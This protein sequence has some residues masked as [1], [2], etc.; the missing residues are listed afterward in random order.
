MSV[1]RSLPATIARSSKCRWGKGVDASE[2]GIRMKRRRLLPST[3]RCG[4]NIPPPA[5]HVRG[6]GGGRFDF[7]EG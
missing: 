3:P 2:G 1:L 6:R 5:Q 4:G 7:G